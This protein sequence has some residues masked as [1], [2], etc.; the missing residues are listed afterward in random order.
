MIATS[1]RFQ[2]GDPAQGA[3]AGRFATEAEGGPLAPAHRRFEAA[4]LRQPGAPAAVWQGRALAY[5]ELDALA[6]RLARALRRRGVGPDVRVAVA[7]ERGPELPVALLAVLKAGGAYVPIDPAYPAERIRYVVQDSGAALVLTHAATEARA[8][9]AGAETLSIDLADEIFRHEDAGA[10]PDDPHP[11]ALAYVIYTSGSTGRPK[12]VGVSHRSLAA[13]C[14]AVVRHFGLTAADRAAQITSI[15]FDISVE[16][17]FPTWAAGGAVVFRP[18]DVPSYG[19]GFLRWLAEER[20]TVLNLPTAFWH[21]WVHDLAAADARPPASLRLLIVGGE[22]AQPAALAQWRRMAPGVRWLNGY[23]PTEATI[24]ATVHEPAAAGEGDI[25]I[26]RPL[27]S[28]TALVLTDALHPVPLG[29]AGELFLGG[30]GVARGYLG[31]PSLTAERFVPDPFAVHPGARLY[32]T[33]DRARLR[34]DGELEFLGRVDAQVKVAGFRVEPGEVEAVLAE[35]PGVAHAAVVAHAFDAAG[36]RLVAYAVPRA[37]GGADEAALRGWMR[38]RLPAWQVPSAVVLLDAMPLSAHG[39]IDRR[40][41][42]AP[43]ELDPLPAGFAEPEEG[44]EDAVARAWREVLGLSHV[45]AEDDFWE[46]GGHSLLGMQVLSRIRQRLGVEL[47]VRALFDAPTVAALAARVDAARGAA[48]HAPQPPLVASRRSG[49]V[50]PSFA[51]ERLWFLHQLEPASP[52]YNIPFAVRLA[53]ELSVDALRGALAEIVRRHEVLRT[54]FRADGAGAWQV[55]HPAPA[56]F[57]LPVEDL[58]A[59][60]P[61]QAGAEVPRRMAAE[62]ARP[63]DLRH[64]PMLRALLLRVRDDEHV[65]VLNLHHVAGDGWSIGVLF[66]E[67]AALYGA[68]YGG[69]DSPLADPPVQYAD[70]AEWQ[71]EW[72]RDDVLDA[73]LAYWRARLE[74]APAVLD[75]PTDRAR[76]AVQSRRGAVR[77]FDVDPELTARLR[78][79]ARGADA[80]LFMVLLA[81]FDGL[82]GRLAGRDDVVVGSP[83][84]GRVRAETEALVGFFVN[85]LVLRTDLGGDPTFRQLVRR[86]RETTLEAYA[87]QDLPFE[88]L[89]EELHPE[90][91]L[92]HDPLF[93]VAFALQNVDMAPVDL[94]GLTLRLEDVDSGTSKF[95][96]FL[97]MWEQ[98]GGLRG[99]L[100]YATDLWDA[101]TVDRMTGLFLRLLETVAVDADRPLADVELLDAEDR[102]RLA[103]WNDTARVLPAEQRVHRLIEAQVARTPDAVALVDGDGAMTYGE[104]DARANR[105]AHH[106]VRRGAGPEA[107]VGICLERSARMVVAMLAVLKAGAAYLPLD[108]SYPAD[109]LAYMLRE[110]GA[111][112]LVTQTSL[113]G[114]LAADGVRIIS[115]D[116]DAAAIAAN[117]SDP[118]RTG[119]EA[120]NAAYVIFTSGSTGRP[121]GV[122]VTH[123]NAAAFFA[124]MDERVGGS[125]PG[126]WLA[127]TRVSFDIHVLELLWT[128]ARGFRVVLQPEP[129]RAGAGDE[130]PA[131]IRRHGVTHLQC[132]PTLA[133]MLVAENGVEALAGLERLLLGGE[134][135]PASLAAQ[136]LAV[137]PDGLVNLYG[138]TETTVWSA[139]HDVADAEGAV[140]IGRPIA[141]TRVHVLDARL[142]P[143]PALVPGELYIA[144]AGVARG[145]LHRP[146]LTAARFVPDP[147]APEPGARMYRTGDRV[148]WRA[149]G[150]LEFLGRMDQQVKI[151]GHRIEPGEIES[152]LERHAAVAAAVVHVREDAPGDPRLVAY[153]IP[154][155]P[156][157]P[158]AVEEDAELRGDQV[159]QWGTIWD[160]TYAG[161]RAA[162]DGDATFD[163]TGW[164]SS[165]TGEPIPAEEMREWVDRTVARIL[166]LHPGRVLELG[167]GMGLL[168]L[169][170]A[171]HAAS[172]LGTDLSPR[173][174][175]A[176]DARV[177]AARGLPP[178]TLMQREAADFGGMEP[179]AFDTAVL[180]SVAQYFPGAAYFADVIDGAVERLADGGAFFIGDVRHRGTLAAFRAAVEFEAAPNAMPLRELRQRARRAVDEEEELVADPDFFHALAE[181]NPRIGRVE[182][183]VK[184][185]AHHN[186]LT[187][188]RYDVVL[189][190]GPAAERP[191]AR[192]LGWDDDGISMDGLRRALASAPDEALA[193]LGVPDARV[194]RELRIAALAADPDGPLTVGD[195]RRALRDDPPAGIDPE[196]VWA[197]AEA[198]GRTAELRPAGPGRF[199]V[200]FHAPGSTESDFPP[201]AVPSRSPDAYTNDPL[202]AAQARELSPRLRAWLRERLPEYMLPSSVVLLDEFP[203]TPNGKLDR[204]ALPAPRGADTARAEPVEPETDTERQLAAIWAEVLR[205]EHVYANDNF[206]D[207][208]GHSLLATQVLSRVRRELGVELPLRAMFEAGTVRALGQRL[209]A[210]TAADGPELVPVPRTGLLPLSFGQERMWFLERMS[211]HVGLY[212]MADALALDGPLDVEA[213]RLAFEQLVAR[214]EVLRTR[215]VEADGLPLQEVMPPPPFALPVDEV[216]EADV[217]GWMAADARAP[218]DLRAGP[219]IRARL[220][221]I[222]P[223]RHVL[224]LCVHHIAADGWSWSVLMRELTLLYGAALRGEDAGLADLPIQYA[225][226]ALWQRAWVRGAEVERQLAYWRGRL[227]G[228]PALLELP[229]DRPRPAVQDERGGVL[230]LTLP[231]DVT[232]GARALARAEGATLYMV[233]LAA[234]SAVLSRWSGQTDVVVGS[235]I[236]GRTRPETEGL[237]GLFINSLALRTDVSGD[238]AFRVLLRRVRETALEAYAHQDLPFEQM[239]QETGVERSLSH[240]PVFQ[241]MLGLQNVPPGSLELEGVRAHLLPDAVATSRFDL[242]VMVDEAGDA[243]NAYVEYATALFDEGTVQRLMDHLQALLRAAAAADGTPIGALPML[244]AAERA[245]VVGAWNAT[246][247]PGPAGVCAHDLFAQQ[248]AL[249]PDAPALEFAGET[250]SYAE[251]DARANRLAR[252]LRALGVRV[253]A[254]VALCLERSLE[255]P[256]AVL[257][258]LKAGGA[259]VPADPAYPAERVA[260]MLEDSGAAV[261]VTTSDVAAHLPRTDTPVLLLDEDADA[262]AAESADPLAVDVDPD[263]LAYVLYTSGSTG[264]P[265][266]AAVPHA[267]LVNLVRWQAARWGAELAPRTLQ[268]ASL[269]FDASFHEMFSTWATGGTLVLIE[270]DRRRD[271][272]A[273]VDY[274]R[275]HRIERIFL[276]FAALQNLAESAEN[277]QLPDLR[278]IITA[279]EAL[280]STP[281]LVAFHRANPALRLDNHYGPSETHV[282]TAHALGEEPADWPLL[283]PIGAPIDNTRTYVLDARMHPAPVGVPGELYIGGIALGRGYLRRPGLTAAAFVPDPFTPGG[284]LY[285]TGDR[286]RWLAAGELEFL[287]RTDDQVKI[288]GFRIEPGEVEAAIASHPSVRDAAVLARGEGAARR[289]VAYVVPAD[290]SASP[291][292]LRAHVAARLPEHMV[293]P[294]WVMLESIP[295]TPSGKMDRRALPEPGAAAPTAGFVAPETETERGLADIW[296]EVLG[297]GGIG[298][299]DSFFALGGH[300]LRA[301]QVMSRIRAAFEVDL[302]LR[303]VFETPRLRAMAERIDAERDASLAALAAELGTLDAGELD[304]LLAAVDAGV[305][306]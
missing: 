214:H 158:E 281:Q 111:S 2:P 295:L 282:V 156:D 216:E 5:A 143:G 98:D 240:A 234:W 285:R 209:H 305:R 199:D 152:V 155:K 229:Y 195:A 176:V 1:G 276:P 128:L 283:P 173:A 265:K 51:Q 46:L 50:R 52:F 184:R 72:L 236:A 249:T 217:R 190:V 231:A 137:L 262:I 35:H 142:R 169:R 269:S 107:Y 207:L 67:L 96:L 230:L 8:A 288:R 56:S 174:L 293:P 110:S 175:Q 90:R 286:A 242:M 178:V 304:A 278:G 77:T 91:T 119:V 218:F 287:G 204:R 228:A 93:Q 124:G 270:D 18:A 9:G 170:V 3:P 150:V 250:L 298:A 31:R 193:V 268:F 17:I 47:P 116:A 20:I 185:G 226:Y 114:L 166:A 296:A 248:A 101:A 88:R 133:A 108:S 132:T 103:A 192:A 59:L 157:A 256:V 37:E 115:V 58:R 73:Q 225:D 251:L 30:G 244:A 208:G 76:P 306:G 255:M 100:E 247:R 148:R 19:A 188:Y 159:Q 227:A 61:E 81:A 147:F 163:I 232:R 44:T 203:L 290:A 75:L 53:G 252:R 42:P 279:G 123:A 83:V 164:N 109:R 201:R 11:D 259:Y 49:P 82:M 121:K 202:R 297:I 165:Y 171:P 16:E 264:K 235:P 34:P 33:G 162:E 95:D 292:A 118:P 43:A 54:T 57:A 222:A 215:Y 300:S 13:H 219:P 129:E 272:E 210:G 238:P 233:L 273:L 70:F 161:S 41:L 125:V 126:T 224:L 85:T 182:V 120:E 191:A 48:V 84:A 289:L 134:A 196:Q 291:D 266:G 145:Y 55:V 80:T 136:V 172:Y 167:V 271:A 78:A 99:H 149:D 102:A 139:T 221:R 60:P 127:V 89:V 206:F 179:R 135:L 12:G 65:L 25:P 177:R 7:M 105:L 79:L 301:A 220:L 24:T 130:I 245:R 117:P 141:N 257:A 237:M 223:E 187:R 6:N 144:G 62:A 39:K 299:E 211:P 205:L 28:S 168:L 40:A 241:V 138:P 94:P 274:L 261:L 63:F 303:A 154:A 27:G 15:G 10:L 302:P 26:G 68:F 213:L 189:H 246:E 14:E 284:R 23:G 106:L 92:S 198:L 29:E 275:A 197:L 243:L 64:D 277:A 263:H 112:L 104:L 181:R 239:V 260:Y 160:D 194:A 186:E 151:R 45:R 66:R 254:P 131:Q 258:V 153:V 69:A 87:H 180:N 86:V 21:A 32:R 4:A 212:N 71:R 200:L 280:R 267:A 146:A 122:Q 38:E 97:E 74:G 113:R 183:R 294:Q 140:P 253:D 22:T 36:T